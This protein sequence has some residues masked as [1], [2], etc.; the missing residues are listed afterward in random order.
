MLFLGILGVAGC[1]HQ[2]LTLLMSLDELTI[3]RFAYTKE[4][5]LPNSLLHDN[6]LY[7]RATVQGKVTFGRICLVED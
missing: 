7:Y 2:E 4:C 3:E 6:T 1:S 5:A